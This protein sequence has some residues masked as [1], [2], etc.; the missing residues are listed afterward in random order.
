MRNFPL[1]LRHHP[2]LGPLQDNVGPT[3]TMAL[4]AG[5]PA[6]DKGGATGLARDQRDVTRIIGGG[7]DIGAVEFD[8][9][10]VFANGFNQ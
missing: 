10:V 4:K 9:D 2:K 1:H 7:D 6:I 8:P 5:S 3:R